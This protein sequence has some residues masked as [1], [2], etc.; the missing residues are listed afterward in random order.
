MTPRERLQATLNHRPVDRLC[1]DMG[2]GGQ[3]GIGVCALHRLRQAVLGDRD[4][5]VRV[6]EPYQML[7]EVDDVL[8]KALGLDVIG[9]PTPG[10]M[11]GYRAQGW[12]PFVMPDGTPCLVPGRF[13]FTRDSGGDYLMYPE[14]DTSVPPCAKMT[15]DGYFFDSIPRQ[16]PI[17]EDKLDPADNLEEF[18][19]ISDQDVSYYI[20]AVDRAYTQTDYG[21]YITIGGAAF[22]DI[23]L[24]PS[25]W[26][27]HPKGIRDVE[28][29]YVS[30][31]SRQPYIKAVFEQQCGIAMGNIERLAKALGDRVQVAFVSGTDFGT[32]TSTFCSVNTFR[33]LYKPYLAAVCDE[34]HRRTTWKVFMHSCGAVYPLIPE[35][36][37]AGVDV[38]NPV[39]CSAAGMDPRRLKREFGKDLVF[40][41]GGVDTQKTLPFGTPDE[42]YKEV[43]ERIDIL[44]EDGTGFVF[45]TIHNILSNVPVEN[46]LAMFRAVNDAR[47][48][49]GLI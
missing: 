47:L 41:G 35:F 6:H 20:D 29:W 10:T 26:L 18:G 27:K 1:V 19:P 16:G 17:Y 14:G 13:N 49:T 9:I 22:G 46:I 24:V 15:Y 45:N 34:I 38:L 7:G 25:P 30:T 37:D 31:F 44:F 42:V 12:K 40:W 2:A 3:T 32:Q 43:R 23:A 21:I 5:M 39:Q 8:R 4:Y 11:F 36:I 33:D 28:E 48:L